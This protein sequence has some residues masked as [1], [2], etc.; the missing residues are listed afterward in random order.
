[1]FLRHHPHLL[2]YFNE[3]LRQK[4]HFL[5]VCHEYPV[6]MHNLLDQSHYCHWLLN[7]LTS[8]HRLPGIDLLLGA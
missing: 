2:H 1:M 5:D 6:R 3:H 8:H 7:F 4:R